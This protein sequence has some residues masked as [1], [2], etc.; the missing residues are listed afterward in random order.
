MKKYKILKLFAAAFILFSTVFAV[1]ACSFINKNNSTT[2]EVNSKFTIKDAY[3]ALKDDGYN[4]TFSEFIKEFFY[5][6]ASQIITENCKPS[7]VSI[8]REEYSSKTGSGV[9]IKIENNSA[10]ILTNYHVAY[11]LSYQEKFYINLADDSNK[12]KT[13]TAFYEYGNEDYDLAILKIENDETVNSGKVVTFADSS[14]AD[15][16]ICIAI[17]NT[18]SKGISVT[19]GTVSK[20]TDIC[21]YIAG[22]KGKISRE[23]LMHCAYIEKGSSG[24]GLFNLAGELIGITNAGESG[25][26]TLQNYAIK[27]DS[28]LD[29]IETFINNSQ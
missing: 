16:E 3:Q 25:D 15:G 18:H 11:P 21:E 23:V 9:F 14:A 19:I 1:S 10:L 2:I 13:M 24:G 28:V 22:A 27:I 4:K 12:T 6:D 17:G 8:S 20:A 29:F 7:V 5:Y 26:T